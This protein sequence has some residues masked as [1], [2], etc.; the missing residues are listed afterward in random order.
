MN[1]TACNDFALTAKGS[2]CVQ[3]TKMAEEH[4]LS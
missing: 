2:G 1:L 3:A 4:C